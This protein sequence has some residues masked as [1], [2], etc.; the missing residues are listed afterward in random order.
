MAT[1]RRLHSHIGAIRAPDLLASVKKL[2]AAGLTRQR[3][4]ALASVVHR[5]VTAKALEM[6]SQQLSL[7]D[8]DSSEFYLDRQAH[9]LRSELEVLRRNETALL[10]KEL[11]LISRNLDSLTQKTSDKIA[12]LKSD[13]TMDLNNHKTERRALST[14]IDLRIQEVHHKLT[15]E[16]SALKTRLETLKMEAT[17]RATWIAIITFGAV[18]IS[19]Q[20]PGHLEKK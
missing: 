16:L 20:D 15:V 2:E 1:M 7:H 13:V 6:R 12:S 11:E 14:R 10:R 3:A 5:I 8:M 19:V 18:F 4:A 9:G 17:Q